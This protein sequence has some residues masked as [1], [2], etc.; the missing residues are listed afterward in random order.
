MLPPT[1]L[2]LSGERFTVIYRLTGDEAQARIKAEDICIEQTIEFPADLIPE[3]DIRRHIFGQ[4][5]SLQLLDQGRY[6]AVISYAVETAGF[7]LTQLLNVIFGNISIK[8]KLSGY[9]KSFWQRNGHL[10]HNLHY[11]I[12]LIERMF[13]RSLT[14]FNS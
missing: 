10:F 13:K 11:W 9:L 14:F 8:R 4:I 7:E 2:D 6:E 3:D 1:S 12:V 5:E